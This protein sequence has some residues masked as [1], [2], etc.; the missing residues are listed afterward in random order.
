MAKVLTRRF[1]V[2]NVE[3]V[4]VGARERGL[5]LR[6]ANLALQSPGLPRRGI[7]RPQV[8]SVYGFGSK[9]AEKND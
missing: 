8:D 4:E 6:D 5:S 3:K 9:L 2:K 1:L 7:L